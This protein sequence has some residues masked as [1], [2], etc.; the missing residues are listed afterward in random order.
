MRYCLLFVLYI[1]CA[2]AQD[3][4]SRPG[5][6]LVPFQVEYYL[7]DAERDIMEQ[8]RKTPDEYRHYFRRTLDL[9]VQA[10]LENLGPC[11]SML[12]DTG[13]SGT[14]QL[15]R[16]YEKTAFVYADPVGPRV[17]SKKELPGLRKNQVKKDD[18]RTAPQ[19]ITTRGD[20]KSMQAMVKD[21]AMLHSVCSRENAKLAVFIN[22]FEIKTNY[23]TCLDISRKIYRRELLVHYSILSPEGR[24]LRSNYARAFFPS[25]SSRDSEIS[26]KVFPEI[27][28]GIYQEVVAEIGNTH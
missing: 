14:E 19:S 20:S 18:A 28:E 12:Q 22:Q 10:R 25:D 2:A 15:E 8:T 13:K 23:T 24:V 27:A 6:L 26:E 11:F 5:T 7:S 1:H 17:H 21:T 3:T 9:K 16:L 4:L